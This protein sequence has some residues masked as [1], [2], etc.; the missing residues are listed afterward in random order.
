MRRDKG[1]AKLAIFELIPIVDR[2]R[3][4]INIYGRNWWQW[5]WQHGTWQVGDVTSAEPINAAEL[6]K[7]R[8]I[9]LGERGDLLRPVELE[10]L[11]PGEEY[12][13]SN[14]ATVSA[15]T[16]AIYVTETLT[17][18][19]FITFRIPRSNFALNLCSYGGTTVTFVSLFDGTAFENE[20]VRLVLPPSDAPSGACTVSYRIGTT[21]T[22]YGKREIPEWRALPAD[23]YSTLLFLDL[24]TE[25]VLIPPQLEN[26]EHVRPISL[27]TRL[28]GDELDVRV[29]READ[30]VRCSFA[31][32]TY[33]FWY[34][35]FPLTVWLE[36]PPDDFFYI[37]RGE[38]LVGYT[39]LD[40]TTLFVT[41]G[42]PSGVGPTIVGSISC[43]WQPLTSFTTGTA[44]LLTQWVK[45]IDYEWS[46]DSISLRT[47]LFLPREYEREE[48]RRYLHPFAPVYLNLTHEAEEYKDGSFVSIGTTTYNIWTFLRQV[49][50]NSDK[51]ITLTAGG[52]DLLAQRPLAQV[53]PPFDGST[54]R[55]ALSFLS[56]CVN[57]PDNFRD[58]S[59]GTRR[60]L[61][62]MQRPDYDELKL[63]W[64]WWVHPK[65]NVWEKM[66]EIA[67]AN[68]YRLV[69]NFTGSLWL[70]EWLYYTGTSTVPS[71]GTLISAKL[72]PQEIN[73]SYDFDQ[74]RSIAVVGGVDQFGRG[75]ITM[76]VNW[77]AL[78]NKEYPLYI[79][80]VEP[81]F[82]WCEGAVTWQQIEYFG[83]IWRRMLEVPPLTATVTFR[84]L[85]TWREG[86]LL[87]FDKVP[88]EIETYEMLI[89]GFGFRPTRVTINAEPGQIPRTVVEMVAHPY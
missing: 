55:Y 86:C 44:L 11:E 41:I 47:T 74:A 64:E 4:A 6:A 72:I 62:R 49:E 1:D 43:V 18:R 10:W 13:T 68:G 23:P 36:R 24:G 16:R 48:L 34:L 50:W 46:E 22:Q 14:V 66:K 76:R 67:E 52:V 63:P 26:T 71:A 42:Q 38:E 79:G 61:M 15:G 77:Q 78:T 85:P 58:F 51:T 69:L 60:L 57:I 87:R 53:V 89:D 17:R 27:P 83:E 88:D 28:I 9:Y 75:Y 8:F 31:K 12:V 56:E 39:E 5:G 19:S 3:T 45:D 70:R 33:P 7:F 40:G 2:V 59:V 29:Y 65:E 82:H 84:G 25:L 80:L 37:Y 81:A 32:V 35:T 73:A 30:G 54:V 20:A 21:I